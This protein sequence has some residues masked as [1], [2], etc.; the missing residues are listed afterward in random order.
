MLRDLAR[1]A[2]TGI[3][4]KEISPVKVGIVDERSEIAGCVKGIPQLNV[5]LRTDVLDA[6]PKAEGM[7]MMIRSMSP[8]VLVADEI[9][10]EED[11]QALS[12]AVNSGV[13]LMVTAHGASLEETMR[14]P[15]MREVIQGGA[16]ERFI[17]LAVHN[18]ER[19]VKVLDQEGCQLPIWTGVRR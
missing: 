18:G 3:K 9:G 5:G 14:R 8:E 16:F 12:E 1:I 7:M 4:E 11:G 2:A 19:I 13:A 6:C 17:E 10:R 15:M